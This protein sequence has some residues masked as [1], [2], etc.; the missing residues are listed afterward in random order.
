MGRTKLK[1][2]WIGNQ[3]ARKNAYKKRM[4]GLIKK[5]GELTILCNMSACL[6]FFSRDDNRLVVWP[7]H[8]VAESLIERFYSLP[9]IERNQ[10]AEDQESFIRTNTKKVENKLANCRKVI[11]ELEMD[12]LMFQIHNGRKLDDLSQTEI[13]KLISYS[14]KKIMGMGR[15]L[16]YTGHPFPCV[17]EP[18]MGNESPSASDV[19]S[20]WRENSFSLMG[21]G[22]I[23]LM[24]QWFEDN[25][26]VEENCDEAHLPT[27]TSRFNLNVEPSDDD[28]DE[29]IKICKGENS[30]SGGADDA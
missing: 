17:Y 15:E 6:I 28:D 2:A 12:H 16:G 3:R 24:D 7:S 8:E 14:S 13:E 25:P 10:K 22:S 26:K 20:E 19:A 9:D 18:F 30:K 23:Y 11:T 27:M 29:D 5:A 4:Q 1:F 21:S